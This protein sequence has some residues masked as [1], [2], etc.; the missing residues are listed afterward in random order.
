MVDALDSK[1][2]E[3][4]FMG[5]RVSP[6]APKKQMKEK[7][8]FASIAHS[9]EKLPE[10]AY[11]LKSL[12][13]ELLLCDLDRFV[14]DLYKPALKKLD[15]PFVFFEY[16]R[17][18]VD[19]NRSQTDISSSTVKGK[20]MSGFQS[21]SDV[22]WHKTTKG[23]TLMKEPIDFSVHETLINK[24]YKPYHDKIKKNFKDL[25]EE[26]EIV[27]FL[28]LHSMP[29]LGLDFHRDPG[30]KRAEV[31]ISDFHSKTAS[32]DFLNLVV[33]SYERV[34]FKTKVNWPYFGG[35]TIKLYGDGKKRQALQV[36]LNR[37]LYM[38][39]ETKKKLP[40]FEEIREKLEE[41]LSL[42][43]KSL[44]TYE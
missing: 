17:Y 36:E 38:D 13:P 11:W 32:P 41:A 28:D 9:G 43:A 1:S 10:E 8:L 16:N 2:S 23:Q 22:H 35:N 44:E 26:G 21:P 27:Y 7:K 34:G 24:Y 33:S 15:I 18:A 30:E 12:P 42:I 25:K 31:V 39:E 3:V 5:V 29:S 14:I 20:T 4:R 19:V 40:Q 6:G 37:S